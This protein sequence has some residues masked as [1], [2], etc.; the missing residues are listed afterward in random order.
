MEHNV[1]K[2]MED[3]QGFSKTLDLLDQAF[4]Y[5]S[6]VE[7][8]RALEKFFYATSRRGEQTLLSYVSDHREA[9]REV[10]KHGIKIPENVSGWLLLRRSGL[11][12]E[13]KQ[14][15]QSR[16]GDLK[17]YEVEQA[18]YYLLGQDY[19]TKMM[20][21]SKGIGRHGARWNRAGHHG[22]Y[23]DEEAY[24]LEDDGDGADY[25][26]EYF[27]E[28]GEHYEAVDDE[29]YEETYYQDGS[30][31]ETEEYKGTSDGDPQLEEAYATYLDARRQFANLKAARGY[32]PVVALAQVL[33]MTRHQWVLA[34]KDHALQKEKEKVLDHVVRKGKEKGRKAAMWHRKEVRRAV[35]PPSWTR[36]VFG[37]DPQTTWLLPVR[38]V[39]MPDE[40]RINPHHQ[41]RDRRVMD[42]DWWWR[43]RMYW[44]LLAFRR[45]A[46]KAVMEF[47]TEVRAV[48]LLATTSSCSSS[49]W[50]TFVEY[51][52]RSS[53]FWPRTRPLVLEAMPGVNRTGRAD[54]QFG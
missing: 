23:M 41:P 9:L 38:R 30:Y 46:S 32:Y 26:E 15:I 11:T 18:L 4:K 16:C 19:K 7:M 3:D 12:T 13:Q 28:D 6:R 48:W 1:D 20:N 31:F 39:L 2:L 49:T 25:D 5:D 14:L 36:S 42:M 52:L 22:Y 43:T 53:S 40:A 29:A 51:L 27:Y 21:P 37:V 10:E 35:H 54:F 17:D 47:K 8:P 33:E 24:Q 45:W 44:N 34:L 50:C